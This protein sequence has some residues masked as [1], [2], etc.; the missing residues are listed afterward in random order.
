MEFAKTIREACK[1]RLQADSASIDAKE[2][3]QIAAA[4]DMAREWLG[5]VFEVF[6]EKK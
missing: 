3:R 5:E 4:Y 1:A 6:E 2:I